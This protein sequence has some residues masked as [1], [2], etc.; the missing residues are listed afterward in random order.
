MS[1]DPDFALEAV[2]LRGRIQAVG[3]TLAWVADDVGRLLG[4]YQ[5]SS[6]LGAVLQGLSRVRWIIM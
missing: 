5:A 2:D 3:P 1:P 6:F 4:F